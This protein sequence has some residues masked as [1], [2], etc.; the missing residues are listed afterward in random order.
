MRKGRMRR[1]EGEKLGFDNWVVEVVGG[2]GNGLRTSH[3][4]LH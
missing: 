3:K 2:R 1:E 4:I